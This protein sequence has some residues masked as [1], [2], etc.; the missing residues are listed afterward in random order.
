MKK[1]LVMGAPGG[2]GYAL[3]HELTS[4][5]VEVAAFSRNREK[6]E[7]LYRDVRNVT[8]FPG[9]AFNPHELSNAAAGV[10]IIF[11]AV[12]FPYS[13]WA[14]KHPQCLDI[15][16]EVAARKKAKVVLINNVYV[17][18]KQNK[19]KVTEDAEKNPYTKKGHIRLEMEKRL[20]ES[21]V[22]TLNLYMPDFYGPNAENTIVNAVLKSVLQNKKARF[23]GSTKVPREFLYTM[24]AAKAMIE[25]AQRPDA[26][27][28]SWN[29]PSAHLITGEELFAII[30][31]AAEYKKT[32]RPITK[33]M[34]RFMGLFSPAMK[35][36][37]EIMDLTE[38]PV[39]LS[40]EKYENN[41]NPL[42]RT[43]YKQGIEE[44]L[45]WMKKK[46]LKTSK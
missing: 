14:A 26:Y 9:D 8:I 21:S 38:N 27:N 29:I 28:Q 32:I 22:P 18:G 15:A 24:D 16:L 20:T 42:P 1:A 31:E 7:S 46:E 12:S 39:V 44:T 3:V 25:L 17:Y 19:G 36:I 40:G 45:C 2:M 23:V 6:L 41:I 5:C 30:R 35:E 34:I 11:Y 13:E 37:V 10:D 33:E 43:S 4:Q